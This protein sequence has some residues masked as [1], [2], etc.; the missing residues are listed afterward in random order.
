MPLLL[1]FLPSHLVLQVV[2]LFGTRRVPA[3]AAVV[4]LETA[5][6]EA[7]RRRS[8]EEGA[9]SSPPPPMPLINCGVDGGGTLDAQLRLRDLAARY[10]PPPKPPP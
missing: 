1:L 5:L 4:A 2:A 7:A 3:G 10:Q 6:D 8:G 9:S